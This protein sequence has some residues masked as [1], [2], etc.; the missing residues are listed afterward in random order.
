MAVI[1]LENWS[2]AGRNKPASSINNHKTVM[3]D[4]ENYI[5]SLPESPVCDCTTITKPQRMVSAEAK[6]AGY[7]KPASKFDEEYLNEKIDAATPIW[8][9][10]DAD[11]FINEIRRG[12]P[13]K[14]DKPVSKD[15][16]AEIQRYYSDVNGYPKYVQTAS[17]FA[18]WQKQQMMKEAKD[19]TVYWDRLANTYRAYIDFDWLGHNDEGFRAGDTVKL[20]IIKNDDGSTIQ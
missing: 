2:R 6:E 20:I 4:K 13:M 8:K 1:S 16:E 9:G 14:K 3:T 11:G 18:R 15:L 10:V 7:S 17:H 5:N 12:V 19:A